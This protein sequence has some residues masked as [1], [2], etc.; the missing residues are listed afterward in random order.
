MQLSTLALMFSAPQPRFRHCASLVATAVRRRRVRY[1]WLPAP[2]RASLWDHAG[3]TEPLVHCSITRI[4]GATRT[5]YLL[6]EEDERCQ[7]GNERLLLVAVRTSPRTTA[8]FNVCRGYAPGRLRRGGATHVAD[9][10]ASFTR[11]EHVVWSADGASELAA[12]LFRRQTVMENAA[13][14]PR[15]RR[16]SLAF[17]ALSAQRTPARRRRLMEELKATIRRGTPSGARGGADG[18]EEG[19]G[20]EHDQIVD[21]HRHNDSDDDAEEEDDED[22]DGDDDDD[23]DD[24]DDNVLVRR[25]R[26]QGPGLIFHNRMPRYDHQGTYRLD[27]HGRVTAA[28]VKNCQIEDANGNLVCQFGRKGSSRDTFALDYKAPM[29]ALQAFAVALANF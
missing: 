18:E 15:P 25:R 16:F 14:G 19:E 1:S 28:S 7:P 22:D 11:T 12:V 27:F 13:E 9:C 26:R 10:R 3:P 5:E 24:D 29:N 4:R 20:N 21:F 8:V 17:P 6:Y 2:E 23:D